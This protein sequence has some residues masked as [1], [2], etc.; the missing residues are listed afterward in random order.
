[1]LFWH[2]KMSV[3]LKGPPGPPDSMVELVGNT[4]KPEHWQTTFWRMRLHATLKNYWKTKGK[5]NI[6]IYAVPSLQE[7][8]C[9]APIHWHTHASRTCLKTHGNI[10]IYSCPPYH[11]PALTSEQSPAWGLRLHATSKNYEKK[12]M[13]NSLFSTMSFQT[14]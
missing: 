5:H 6:S 13:E 11:Q 1:M 3:R 2:Q 14:H 9:I 10:N 7:E 8:S 4:L 12:H